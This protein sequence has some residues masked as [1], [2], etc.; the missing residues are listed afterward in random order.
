MEFFNYRSDITPAAGRLLVSEPML[1][2]PNFERTVILLCVHDDDGSLGFV[3]NKPADSLLSDL[4]EWPGDDQI[5][6]FIGGPV[7]GDTLQFIHRYGDIEG[8]REILP[9]I[10]WGGDFDDLRERAVN[11]G[12]DPDHIRFFLGYSGWGQGQLAEELKE[13]AWIVSDKVDTDMI[14][15]TEPDDLWPLVLRKMGGRFARFVN[16]PTD[17]RLN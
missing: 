14:F 5:P 3:L 15:A 1:A 7:Q 4:V 2:D 6:V 16:Y 12:I 9:G 8:C 13:N 10:F 17:P 11:C